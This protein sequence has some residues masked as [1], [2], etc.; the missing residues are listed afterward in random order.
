MKI[1]R[2]YIYEKFEK[3]S[4]P[5]HDMGI[6]DP[7][8]VAGGKL[9]S[10]AKEHGYEFEMKKTRK[11]RETPS[12]YVPIKPRFETRSY[13]QGGGAMCITKIKY[14][15]TYLPDWKDTPFSL[16]KVWMGYVYVPS[17]EE[18]KKA[19]DSVFNTYEES[20]KWRFSLLK[21]EMKKG[22]LKEKALEQ[23]LMGR[24]GDVSNLL[25]RMSGNIKKEEIKNK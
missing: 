10:F 5:V 16:R 9:Q 17:D 11:N 4:D 8:Y 13:F 14:T 6:G 20:E 24:Y 15:I 23:Q 1:V 22:T 21:R 12:L 18:Y 25:K 19:P 2:E 3:E 7:L